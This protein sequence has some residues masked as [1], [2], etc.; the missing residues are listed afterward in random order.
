MEDK[1]AVIE[2]EGVKIKPSKSG[3][4]KC[5]FNCHT[6]NYPAPKWKTEQGIMKHL[7]SCRSRPS[8]VKRLA[9]NK[10]IEDEIFEGLK[11]KALA[12]VT[13][14]VG[15]KIYWVR[16]IIVKDTHEQRGNRL[17]KVRYEPVLRFEACETEIKTID[18]L[19]NSN[20]APDAEYILNRYVYFNTTIPISSVRSSFDEAKADARKL[21]I[22]DEKYRHESSMLR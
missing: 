6:G 1:V 22:Q 3:V 10:E 8:N 15:D 12:M 16:K 11:K 14:K 18:V 2:F 5:P 21:T 4:Y 9:E 20:Y 13:Q 7:K 17:V 19:K